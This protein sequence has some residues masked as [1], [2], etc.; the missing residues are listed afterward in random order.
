MNLRPYSKV[1]V[2]AAG[3]AGPGPGALDTC[4]ALATQVIMKVANAEVGCCKSKP[5]LK[6]PGFCVQTKI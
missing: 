1:N 5:V 4:A 2:L 6:A 3:D